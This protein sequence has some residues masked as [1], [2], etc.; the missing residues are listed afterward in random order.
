MA[1]IDHFK[2]ADDLISHLNSTMGSVSDPFISSRYVG[3]VA[4]VC[5]TVF[6][7]A[8]KDIFIEFSDKKHKVFGTFTRKYFERINGKIKYK[9][10]KNDYL[11]RYGSKYVD[12]Y[13]KLIK[14]TSDKYLRTDG[15]DILSSYNNI[16]TWRN[17]FAHE[18]KIPTTATYAEV[19]RSFEAGKEV[20]HCLNKAL[21]R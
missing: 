13:S 5:V 12:K 4:V 19:I 18:G 7:L 14:E 9:V 15:I 11:P 10:L 1:Y 8:I 6:E 17:Q 20:I 3:F 2:L 16:I 21:P